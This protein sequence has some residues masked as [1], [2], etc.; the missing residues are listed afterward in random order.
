MAEEAIKVFQKSLQLFTIIQPA[1]KDEL[2]IY[3]YSSEIRSVSSNF[4]IKM[5]LI[6]KPIQ[7]RLSISIK[8]SAVEHHHYLTNWGREEM[9]VIT[10][11]KFP[12]TCPMQ[13][14]VLQCDAMRD[15]SRRQLGNLWLQC[16]THTCVPLTCILI[17]EPLLTP[18]SL[19][20]FLESKWISITI[21]L[22]FVSKSP[23]NTIPAWRRPGDKPLSEPM[24]VSLYLRHST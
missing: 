21:S 5:Y 24:M 8:H 10:Q 19:V 12:N 18:V 17:S 3:I 16:A 7:R 23:I 13:C 15:F 14:N 11:T 20:H 6:Y 22:K 2:Y 9:A 1:C 4:G